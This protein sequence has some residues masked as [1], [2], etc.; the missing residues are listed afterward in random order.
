MASHGRCRKC[1]G[2]LFLGE[3]IYSKYLHC[4]QCGASQ[5]L[6]G[7]GSLDRELA[8]S[9]APHRQRLGLVAPRR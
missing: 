7:L 3:D 1:G 5:E 4:L 9:L 2:N 8:A 6:T